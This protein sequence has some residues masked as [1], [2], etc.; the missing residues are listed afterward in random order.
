MG[1]RRVAQPSP[2]HPS[3]YVQYIV[4]AINDF[5]T[6]IELHEYCPQ[7]VLRY[8]S[9]L[10]ETLPTEIGAAL[11]HSHRNLTTWYYITCWHTFEYRNNLLSKLKWVLCRSW[12][13]ATVTRQYWVV[14]GHTRSY[15]SNFI[16]ATRSSPAIDYTQPSTVMDDS[17]L[18]TVRPV[19]NMMSDMHPKFRAQGRI[20]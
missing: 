13:K 14:L 6:H 9:C 2:T 3:Y 17:R 12:R 15:T 5:S 11:Y 4:L 20:A 16:A 19:S 7:L 18:M 10:K 1:S 8:R